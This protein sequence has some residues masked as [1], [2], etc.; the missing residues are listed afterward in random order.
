MFVCA[1]EVS[2]DRFSMT[3]LLLTTIFFF[4]TTGYILSA[5]LSE[6]TSSVSCFG[7]YVE[8]FMWGPV[9]IRCHPHRGIPFC[10]IF[11]WKR[12][13]VSVRIY[14]CVFTTPAATILC[15]WKG[16]ARCPFSTLANKLKA[17]CPWPWRSFRSPEACYLRQS[18]DGFGTSIFNRRQL[19]WR[20][21][22]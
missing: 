18:A 6:Y 21:T 4:K 19:R 12:G 15:C 10:Q 7:W 17:M 2:N 11:S 1:P 9:V 3:S 14:V 22:Y 16:A 20:G 8:C 5:E 13:V